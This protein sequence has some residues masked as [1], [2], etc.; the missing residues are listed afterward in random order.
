MCQTLTDLEPGAT[1]YWR[2]DQIDGDG[3][4]HTGDVWRFVA[5][6]NTAYSPIPRD[7]DKWID[8]NAVL[9]W[10]PGRTA[11]AHDVY[12]GTDR[13]AVTVRD[14][15]AFIANLVAPMYRPG[16][17]QPG[18]TYYWAVD[19]I[20]DD[21][22][23]GAV[24]S[25]TTFDGGG[26]RAEYFANMTASGQ[27]FL[28]QVEETVDHTWDEGPIA[29]T[30][31]DGVSAR[32][33]AD[34]EIAIG[35][36]YTF[37]TTSDDG[38][39]LWLD[40]VPLID[41][42]TTHGPMDD[43][44]RP[45]DLAPGIYTLRMEWYDYCAGATAQLWWQTPSMG[46]QILPPGPL[47]PP[48]R[49]IPL[50]PAGRATNVSRDVVLKW[51]PGE[52]A[53]MHDVYFGQDPNAVAEATPADANV[54]RYTLPRGQ[55]TWTPGPLDSGRTYYWRIDEVNPGEPDSPWPG[56][57]NSF[58]TVADQPPASSSPRR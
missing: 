54:Y 53:A 17:L 15:G 29:G 35:D 25:F 46:R 42:W 58:T 36:T 7:G 23:D 52:R 33:T 55:T 38:V 30:L 40:G 14:P 11:T 31:V 1:Y 2:V 48:L 26:V 6:P 41:N 37:I 24:W 27:P 49:A 47:Q 45:L 57:V 16:P 28:T 43:Y 9:T 22:Y 50:Y 51:S 21:R 44:S 4:V 39:R 13:D 19:E 8:P 34:L 10:L 18:V 56:H 20:G 3:S 5:T 12:F 32:W